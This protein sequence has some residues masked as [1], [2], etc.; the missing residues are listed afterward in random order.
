M[1]DSF[2]TVVRG[3]RGRRRS[4]LDRFIQRLAL[5]LTSWEVTSFLVGEY[6][7][8]E[9]RDNPVFTVADGLFWLSQG[10][11]EIRW[12]VSSRS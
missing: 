3:A 9:L 11:I 10:R 2:R 6:V 1:V 5:H 8:R 4:D 7:E 12:F